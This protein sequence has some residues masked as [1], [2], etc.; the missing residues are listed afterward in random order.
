[1]VDA[2]GGAASWTGEECFDWAGGRAGDNAGG[3]GALIVGKGFAAQGN[4]LVGKETV[5]AMARTFE[6]TNGS[7]SDRLVAALVAGGKAGGD[8]RGEQS[9]ALLVKRA[10]GSYDGSSDDY[11]DISIYDHA[12]PLA[13]L[14]RLYALHKL[15]FFRSEPANLIPVDETL[16]RELQGILGDARYKG[17]AFYSGPQD[18]VYDADM[19]QALYNF[20]GWENYDVRIR[21]DEFI[22][23]EVLEDI[24]KNYSAW[25]SSKQ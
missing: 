3:K 24:R 10:G 7:L 13:E 14:E 8:K 4:I 16:C 25:K 22:D 9:A 2:A 18:G 19:K 1:V 23:R 15:F 21:S 12:T 20:M 5:E 11:I 17:Q 6:Q